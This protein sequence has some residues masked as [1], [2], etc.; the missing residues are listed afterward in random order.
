MLERKSYVQRPGYTPASPHEAFIVPLLKREIDALLDGLTAPRPGVSQ[1]LDVGC[2]RQPF[3]EVLEELG[4][5]YFSTDVEQNPE[6]TTHFICEIDR[7]LPSALTG[8]GS[9]DLIFCTEVL[10]HVADWDATFANFGSILNRG[11]KV[12]LTCPHFYMLHLEP[13]DFWRP[14]PHAFRFFADRHGFAVRQAKT[15]GDAWDILGTV[16]ASTYSQPK[17]RTFWSRFVNR[18]YWTLHRAVLKSLTDGSLR[19][20]VSIESRFTLYQSNIVLLEKQ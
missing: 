13:H 15:A 6:G 7:P 17:S 18:C 12:L 11:G 1:V 3:R 14:T 20:N 19:R 2:G 16:L 5:R 8:A 9:F 4:Y 10:E